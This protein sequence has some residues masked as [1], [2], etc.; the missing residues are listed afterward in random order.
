MDAG[1]ETGATAGVGAGADTAVVGGAIGE[2]AGADTGWAEGTVAWAYVGAD[3]S[4]GG[5]MGLT[6]CTMVR[7]GRRTAR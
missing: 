2:A 6:A 1:A 5:V 7:W 4:E 3:E